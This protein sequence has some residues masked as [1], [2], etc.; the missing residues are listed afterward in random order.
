MKFKIGRYYYKRKTAEK[1]IKGIYLLKGR[2]IIVPL[3]NVQRV[4]V[5]IELN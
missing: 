5:K 4:L 2:S 3:M 1:R